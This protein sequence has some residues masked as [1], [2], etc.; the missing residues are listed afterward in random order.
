MTNPISWL[1]QTNESVSKFPK[2][3]INSLLYRFLQF[4]FT[5]IPP[6]I[7]NYYYYFINHYHYHHHHHHHHH[8][9]EGRNTVVQ[10]M[11]IYKMQCAISRRPVCF[12]GSHLWRKKPANGPANGMRHLKLSQRCCRRSGSAGMWRRVCSTIV[13]DFTFFEPCFMIYLRNKN[14]Q[15][16]HFL[17]FCFNLSIASLTYFEHP[18][19]QSGRWQDLPST[20]QILWMHERNNV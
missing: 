5:L 1:I 6:G 3:C 12:N 10:Q 2:S 8:H 7:T 15:N 17:H 9:Q 20:R 16:A 4:S 14:K 11:R 18:Y 13:P 19:M